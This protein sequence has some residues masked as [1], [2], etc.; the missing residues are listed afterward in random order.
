MKNGKTLKDAVL[1]GY[2]QEL[3]IRPLET[4]E[5]L[6]F[7]GN[8]LVNGHVQ[9][10]K[11]KEVASEEGNGYQLLPGDIVELKNTSD[12]EAFLIDLIKNGFKALKEGKILVESCTVL[13]KNNKSSD[14]VE[15]VEPWEADALDVDDAISFFAAAGCIIDNMLDII[16][17]VHHTPKQ[18]LMPK[19][20]ALV[21]HWNSKD[22][23]G[24]P[25]CAHIHLIISCGVSRK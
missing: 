22:D 8:H 25:E 15:Y 11:M 17:K 24:K 4:K 10:M 14:G 7:S 18:K 2:A 16:G 6:L 20:I 5:K 21:Y 1:N 23:S 9:V 12:R 19:P 13:G 3:W